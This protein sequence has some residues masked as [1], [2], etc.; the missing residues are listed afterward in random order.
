MH[1][2]GSVIR[3]WKDSLF[4]MLLSSDFF[5]K[6]CNLRT[7]RDL[8]PSLRETNNKP[9]TYVPNELISEVSLG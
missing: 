6:L 5:H 1:F 8:C 2:F 4:T 3:T 9:M 7:P